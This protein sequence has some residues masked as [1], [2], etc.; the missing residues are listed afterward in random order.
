MQITYKSQYSLSQNH[1]T[2]GICS[3]YM[4]AIVVLNKLRTKVGLA[5]FMYMS[6]L[7]V[8]CLL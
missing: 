7:I 5:V 6:D 8:T 3:P 2:K 1:K 4:I